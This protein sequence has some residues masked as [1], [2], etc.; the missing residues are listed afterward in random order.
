MTNRAHLLTDITTD[1]VSCGYLR[2]QHVSRLNTIGFTRF[3]QLGTNRVVFTDGTVVIKIAP[4]WDVAKQ[5]E[6]E[7]IT[8]QTTGE[9]TTETS[10][11]APNHPT[12]DELFCPITDTGPHYRWVEMPLCDRTVTNEQVTQFKHRLKKS[13]W[14][15]NDFH[16]D[17][18]GV[19][20]TNN[21]SRV[22][23][24]DYPEATHTNSRYQHTTQ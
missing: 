17:N 20:S 2:P 4:N 12:G 24:F 16:K 8:W 14:S 6:A 7:A 15:L 5:N 1:I 18:L 9:H 22:V 21:N 13:H 10:S 3:T 11:E 23:C 19:Y